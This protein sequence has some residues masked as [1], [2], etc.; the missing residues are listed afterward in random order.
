[1]RTPHRCPGLGCDLCEQL[2]PEPEWADQLDARGEGYG[3][4]PGGWGD[5]A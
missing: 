5:A 4:P 2:L 3:V 1:M